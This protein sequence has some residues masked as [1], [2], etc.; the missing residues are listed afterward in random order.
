MERGEGKGPIFRGQREKENLK[1][2]KNEPERLE[3]SER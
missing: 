2:G 3:T 1:A